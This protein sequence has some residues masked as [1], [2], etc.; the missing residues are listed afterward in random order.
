MGH[1]GSVEFTGIDKLA[2]AMGQHD[3]AVQR[4]ILG[5]FKFAE[6]EATTYAKQN[7][8]WTDRT[9]NAR[10]GLHSETLVGPGA[11][12]FELIVAGSV[13]YQIFLETRFSGK[14][15]IIMPTINYIGA[16]LMNRIQS[17]L[18]KMGGVTT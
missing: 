1:S 14:Y 13:F 9:G 12:S 7:A 11:T 8:P 3:R 17:S 4:V 16:L 2:Q 10:A 6:G 5:Q 18:S 15:A